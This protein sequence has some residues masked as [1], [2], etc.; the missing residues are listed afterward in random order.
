MN[1]CVPW[2]EDPDLVLGDLAQFPK[3]RFTDSELS[4]R[5]LHVEV[6]ELRTRSDQPVPAFREKALT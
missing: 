1:D 3:Q 5:L 4:E 6:L 2:S